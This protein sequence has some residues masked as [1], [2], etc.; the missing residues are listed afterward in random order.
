M[1]RAKVGDLQAMALGHQDVFFALYDVKKL[2]P[3]YSCIVP[4]CN[5]VGSLA[6]WPRPAAE[7][8]HDHDNY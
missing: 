7:F 4:L 2:L 5:L 1:T 6:A 8:S 3:T